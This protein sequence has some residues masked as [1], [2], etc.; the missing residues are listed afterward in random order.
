M[1]SFDA[2][3]FSLILVPFWRRSSQNDKL[4]VK[5]LQFDLY[6]ICG[7]KPCRVVQIVVPEKQKTVARGGQNHKWN[8]WWWF[9]PG[10]QFP[11]KFLE[12]LNTWA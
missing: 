7:L 9:L 6:I 12:H 8:A 1:L 4:I 2:Y 5:I 10:T 3:M 11:N